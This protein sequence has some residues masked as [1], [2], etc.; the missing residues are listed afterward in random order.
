M[1]EMKVKLVG[2][3]PIMFHNERLANPTDPFTRELKTLTKQKNKTD[4]ILEQ[5]KKLEWRAGFYENDGRPVV[6]EDGLLAT[7]TNG[8]KKIKKGTDVK[9]AVLCKEPFFYLEYEGPKT[10][11][12]LYD[13]GGFVDYRSVVVSQKRTM[14]ARP[15]FR[16]WSVTATYLY[17]EEIVS[18]SEMKQAIEIA[19]ER[20]GL[21]ERRPRCGRFIVEHLN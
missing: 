18:P 7:L 5:I 12:K 13:A 9:A 8:A 4:E 20:I 10:I 3:A 1:K 11:E 6:P 21:Y 16:N 19:G 17:D 14:R 15:I 2:V